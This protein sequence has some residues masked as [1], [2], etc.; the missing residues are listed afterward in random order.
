M[1]PRRCEASEKK[2]VFWIGRLVFWLPAAK[3]LG[4]KG[5]SPDAKNRG[6]ILVVE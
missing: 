2:V 1:Y 5:T 4:Q 3:A 6:V